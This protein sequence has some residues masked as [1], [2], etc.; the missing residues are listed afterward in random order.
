VFGSASEPQPVAPE[1]A[2]NLIGY[3]WLYALHARSSIARGKFW[4]AEYML[5]EMRNHVLA[6]ACVRRGLPAREGRGIDRLPAEVTTPFQDGLVRSLD[7][8]ELLRAFRVVTSGLVREMRS[9]DQELTAR[10][11]PTL[12]DLT[13]IAAL[14]PPFPKLD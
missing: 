5:S 6:L 11:E 12:Y 2:E 10:L 7:A 13:E 14:L 1:T 4:Q 3:A 8:N 9:F